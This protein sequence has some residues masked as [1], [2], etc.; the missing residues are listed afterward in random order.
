MILSRLK[1][2]ALPP[3]PAFLFPSKVS[4][5]PCLAN[6]ILGL[7]F[8]TVSCQGGDQPYPASGCDRR[9]NVEPCQYRLVGNRPLYG[10][11]R[12]PPKGQNVRPARV[13]GDEVGNG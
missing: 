13:L 9:I 12:P 2:Q 5:D 4:F 3:K 11:F 8:L 10:F 1:P 7:V 6:D